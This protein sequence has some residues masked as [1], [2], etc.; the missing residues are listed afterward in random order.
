MSHDYLSRTHGLTDDVFKSDYYLALSHMLESLR[1]SVSESP[2]VKKG[3]YHYFINP[4]TDG[5]PRMRPELLR[6]ITSEIMER[7]DFSE[8]DCIVA[9]ES[10]GIHLA[11]PISL[12]LG[13]PYV[14]VRKR[15]YGLPGELPIHQHTGYSDT[16]MYVNGLE[17]GEKVIVIDD[18]ISTGGTL[19]AL[20]EVL[21]DGCGCKISDVL[22]VFDKGNGAAEV[23]KTTGI[24]VKSLLR[25]RY[26]EGKGFEP[27]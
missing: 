17:R 26:V 23:E 9:P 25:I 6:E 22:V 15:K 21:R 13:I 27:Y 24:K 14:I 5:V 2:V 16:E 10:M 4:V 20:L 1:K 18:V 3:G 19:S 11:V 8:C 7:V 12:E